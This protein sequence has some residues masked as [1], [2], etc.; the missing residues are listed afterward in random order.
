MINSY[1]SLHFTKYK[2]EYLM[3][4]NPIIANRVILSLDFT[5][6]IK[7]IS[8]T[9]KS[10]SCQRMEACISKSLIPER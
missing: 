2:D 6:D 5:D 4:Q 7:K 10:Y 8:V 3:V 1:L 9:I